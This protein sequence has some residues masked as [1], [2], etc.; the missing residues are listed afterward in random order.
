MIYIR[1]SSRSLVKACEL[2]GTRSWY[3]W[4]LLGELGIGLMYAYDRV[5][6]EWS[7]RVLRNHA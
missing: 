2:S 3:V 1:V 4:L 5:H 7:K 6:E